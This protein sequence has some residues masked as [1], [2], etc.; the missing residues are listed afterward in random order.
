MDS[1]LNQRARGRV[2]VTVELLVEDFASSGSRKKNTHG[3][4]LFPTKN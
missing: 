3:I 4:S 1:T 2:M